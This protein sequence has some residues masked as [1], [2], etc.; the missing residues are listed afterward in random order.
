MKLDNFV[1]YDRS[2]SGTMIIQLMTE[3]DASYK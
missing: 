3:L 1:T 2:Q